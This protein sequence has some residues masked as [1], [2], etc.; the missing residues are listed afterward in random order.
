MKIYMFRLCSQHFRIL[1]S[2]AETESQLK[3]APTAP[4]PAPTLMF[5]TVRIKTI[6][7]IFSNYLYEKR[8]QVSAKLKT[9]KF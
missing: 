3:V 1:G 8:G 5:Y 2:F 4:A 6:H 9:L 7:E